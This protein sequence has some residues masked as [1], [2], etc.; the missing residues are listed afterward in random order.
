MPSCDIYNKTGGHFYGNIH[1]KK[2]NKWEEIY[3]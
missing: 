1:Y 2:L 3:W